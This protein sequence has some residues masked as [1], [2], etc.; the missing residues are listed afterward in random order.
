M[1]RP[2]ITWLESRLAQDPDDIAVRFVIL[3]YYY[4]LARFDSGRREEYV[5]HLRNQFRRD[6]GFFVGLRSAEACMSAKDADWEISIARGI[7]SGEAGS[8]CILTDIHSVNATIVDLRYRMKDVLRAIDRGEAVTVLYR[9]KP[10]ATLTPFHEA[11]QRPDRR[12]AR[13]EEQP[14]FGLW[15]DREDMEDPDSWLRSVRKPRDFATKTSAG[16]KRTVR[17]AR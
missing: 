7:E 3:N 4:E 5:A 16:V 14:F 12:N 1:Q 11:S 9:G 8:K 17:K 13:T 6:P 10:K 15:R 2:A